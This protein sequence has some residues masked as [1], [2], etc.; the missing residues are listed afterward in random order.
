MTRRISQDALD[1][2]KRWEGLVLY[3]YDDTDP[4]H[5]RR[6]INPGDHVKGKL[7]IGYG[8]TRTARPGMTITEAEAERLFRG[9]LAPCEAAVDRIVTVPLTDNQFGTLVSFAFNLGHSTA[10]GQPLANIAAVLN[11]G[12]Y[13]GALRRMGLYVKQRQNGRLVTVPGLVNR[14]AA[15]A[16]LWVR[17]DFVASQNVAAE[18]PIPSSPAKEVSTISGVAAAAAAAAP[19]VTSLSGVH[20]AVGVALVAGLVALA[21]IWL[22]RRREA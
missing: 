1:H 3:A 15:E 8:H 4:P 16:G 22:I 6:R 17:G 18:A 5:A 13:P 19:A 10:K 11:R 2:L 21:A 7:T 20:W 12:D 9:D 14:R